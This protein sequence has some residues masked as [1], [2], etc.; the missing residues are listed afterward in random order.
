[1]PSHIYIRVGRYHEASLANERAIDADST[2]AAQSHTQGLYPVAYMPHN[3]HF[4]WATATMEGRGQRAIEAAQSMAARI[5]TS[6]MRTPGY[7][8]LQHYWVTP[9]YAQVRFGRW[10]A[11]LN[12]PKPADDLIY[13]TAVWH[14]ARA[15]A[16]IR[17]DQLDRAEQA[18]S[19]LQA[20]T[21]HPKLDEVTVWDINSTADITQIA[22][23]VVAGELA[24]AREDYGTAI[25]H[26]E[27]GA[28]L[29]DNLNYDEPPTWHHP[30]R[31]T[32]GAVLLKAGRPAEA[33]QAYRE[34]LA[35]FPD[36]GWSLYGLARSLRAQGQPEAATVVEQRFQDAWQYA[37]V[38]LSSSRM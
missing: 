18:L 12:R 3:Y 26:L 38:T 15:L 13:P 36:N 9:L 11:I 27:E 33:E 5:D 24:A 16:F 2:Y 29:E 34:D 28:R 14:Y 35:R 37:D 10:D 1:M 8:T 4:L 21:N 30:V 32:L 19:R 7:G 23:K 6:Q 17:T 20:L 31:Q 25:Q 22:S